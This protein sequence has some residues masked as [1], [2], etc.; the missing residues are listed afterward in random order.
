M[1][2]ETAIL[3]LI[4]ARIGSKGVPRKNIRRLGD[5]PL[6][7]YAIGAALESSFIADV[8]VSTDD[9]EIAEIARTWGA[10]TPFLRPAELA[11]DA[12]KQ[13][14]VIHHA[15]EWL[16]AHDRYY[17]YVALLQP[18]VPFRLAFDIDAALAL[19]VETAADSVITVEQIDGVEPYTY[20]SKNE[21][22]GLTPFLNSS[23]GGVSRQD[24]APLYRRNGGVYAMKRDVIME[25]NTLY[26]DDCRGV[27]MPAE[28][29]LNI[30]SPFDWLVAEALVERRKKSR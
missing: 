2:S 13:I 21:R 7:A 8:I 11:T 26:G 25:Q 1:S 6:I 27:E 20:Y 3:G 29:S 19:L 30:D 16:E 14:D 10:E 15:L 23:P 12:A 17:D 18:T 4:N 5:R 9:P 22:G 28:R 24:Y